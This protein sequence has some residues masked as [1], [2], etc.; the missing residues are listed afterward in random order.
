MPKK[1]PEWWKCDNCKWYFIEKTHC[2]RAP[3]IVAKEEDDFCAAFTDVREIGEK[4][5]K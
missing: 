2:H 4:E 1:V 5:E 3:Q